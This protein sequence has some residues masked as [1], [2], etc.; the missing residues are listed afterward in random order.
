M[1]SP[2]SRD[3]LTQFIM[4]LS[5]LCVLRFLAKRL[6]LLSLIM[7]MIRMLFAELHPHTAARWHRLSI[8]PRTSA[9]SIAT[10]GALT[11]GYAMALLGMVILSL[12]G[13]LPFKSLPVF[14]A[15]VTCGFLF[16][17][18]GMMAVTAGRRRLVI[19]AGR[20][21]TLYR[22]LTQG[23]VLVTVTLVLSLMALR[24]AP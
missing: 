8:I 18:I 4:L 1:P 24:I 19:L 10:I 21:H 23:L 6:G 7:R 22:H 15:L 5:A 12:L 17:G 9:L 3:V 16:V 2:E 11:T 13:I 20:H 14:L